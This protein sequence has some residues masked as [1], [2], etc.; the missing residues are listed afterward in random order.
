MGSWGG[1]G[2]HQTQERNEMNEQD[3]AAKSYA[4]HDALIAEDWERTERQERIDATA[5][6]VFA[7]IVNST[8]REL[9]FAVVPEME[10]LTSLA[11]DN[12]EALE[13][14]RERRLKG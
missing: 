9:G 2:E 10:A 8:P 1:G 6:A 4:E 5:R 7:R 12:A 13:A 11:Y 3:A 14:E